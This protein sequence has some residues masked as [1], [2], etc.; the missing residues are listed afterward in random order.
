MGSRWLIASVLF[1]SACGPTA[2]T[3]LGV[4]IGDTSGGAPD[5]SAP[6]TGPAD[7]GPADAGQP[8]VGG[9]AEP[10]VRITTDMGFITVKLNPDK[11]PKSVANFL[12]YV[13]EGF[14]DGGDGKGQ[15]VFHRVI[16]GFMVQG[17]GLLEDMSPKATHGAIAIESDNGLKNLRGTIAM[18]RTNDP[19]S[20]TSQFYINHVDNGGLDYATKPPGY[21]V[22]GEVTEGL[23]VVD[24]IAAVKTG[25]KNNFKDVP[26]QTIAITSV[27]RL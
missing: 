26:A 9:S 23:D 20:A 6:D 5:T 17:G 15:T 12:A 16:K 14:Y 27:K 4:P 18:A 13:D 25:T 24:A 21:T 2:G 7:A 3:S 22:F 1:L 10:L 11:A 8:D 19:N